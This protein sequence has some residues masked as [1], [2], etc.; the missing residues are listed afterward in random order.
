MFEISGD[1]VQ[2]TCRVKRRGTIN[3]FK[4]AG[5]SRQ[6]LLQLASDL[7][8]NFDRYL[9]FYAQNKDYGNT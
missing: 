6:F 5:W 2:D 1:E 3:R 7:T 8:S 9:L 4:P